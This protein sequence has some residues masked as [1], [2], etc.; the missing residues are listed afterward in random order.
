MA[1]TDS[2]PSTPTSTPP[3]ARYVPGAPPPVIPSKNQKKKRKSNLKT[4]VASAH[5]AALTDHAPDAEDIKTGKVDPVLLANPAPASS[6]GP[7]TGNNTDAEDSKPA[8]GEKSVVVEAISKRVKALGKKVQRANEYKSQTE[9]LNDDQKAV[10]ATL[11]SLEAGIKEL[12]GI[13]K[14]VETLETTT[15]RAHAQQ[16][17][18]EQKASEQ[19]IA[20]AAQHAEAS[21]LP[22]ITSL[23][24]FLALRD[25]LTHS[26]PTDLSISDAERNAILSAGDILLAHPPLGHVE[27][28][29]KG[30][31]TGA[32]SW[33]GVDYGRLLEITSQFAAPR[34]GTPIPDPSIPLDPTSEP[35]EATEPEPEIPTEPEYHPD[36]TEDPT[37]SY[38][39]AEHTEADV[40]PSDLG[41]PAHSTSGGGFHFMQE[42]ELDA[43]SMSESQEWVAV[44]PDAVADEGKEEEG[45]EDYGDVAREVEVAQADLVATSDPAVAATLDWAA[46]DGD[47]ELPSL[48]SLQGTYRIFLVD[49]LILT[50]PFRYSLPVTLYV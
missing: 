22:R 21:L 15:R 1:T 28:V 30:F 46:H 10:V 4:L 42:S 36:T 31:L 11:P 39:E 9:K 16:R 6:A 13:K 45:V 5:D 32:G 37:E 7:D 34:P 20:E 40:V 43:P 41:F 26:T 8:S 12:E 23:L 48:D 49:Y 38:P 18:E 3:A 25:L 24:S 33:D 47:D 14:T 2:A 19:R 27:E 17:A 50:A 35:L 44:Q 29:V